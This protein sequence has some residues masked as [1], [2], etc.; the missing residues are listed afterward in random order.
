MYEIE[1]GH[2]LTKSKRRPKGSPP[3]N[4]VQAM[5]DYMQAY[6]KAYGVSSTGVRYENG[7]IYADGCQGIGLSLFR[8]KINRLKSR[9]S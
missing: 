4:V 8:I 9:V 6:R 3:A 2:K 7:F 5:N 1:N